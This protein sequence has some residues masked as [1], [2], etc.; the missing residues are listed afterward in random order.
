MYTRFIRGMTVHTSRGMTEPTDTLSNLQAYELIF[1]PS[2]TLSYDWEG[3]NL[4]I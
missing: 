3:L 4:V 1:H 2:G